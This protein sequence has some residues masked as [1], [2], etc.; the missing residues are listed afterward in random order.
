MKEV[1]DIVTNEFN[2]ELI[3]NTEGLKLRGGYRADG[4]ERIAR[5]YKFSLS[6][7]FNRRPDAAAI[8]IVEDDLLFSP[9]FYE[10]F[11]NVAPILDLDKSLF[12]ISAWNDNGFKG[13]VED[14]L[15]LKRTEFFPG[16]GWLLPR[17]L[18]K[19]LKCNRYQF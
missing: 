7:A 12:V 13:K 18:Y 19:V 14:S 1:S 10:Y 6:Q 8:I 17:T 4:A 11:N 3:L 2:L 15:A 9:D 16:L 5:H